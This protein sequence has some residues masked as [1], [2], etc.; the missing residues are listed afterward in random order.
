[1]GT[2]CCAVD[3]ATTAS[4]EEGVA[5]I[6]LASDGQRKAKSKSGASEDKDHRKHA[7]ELQSFIQKRIKL[8]EEYKQR[9]DQTVSPRFACPENAIMDQFRFATIDN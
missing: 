7:E 8:F 2:D 4:V 1:M 6:Q 5:N 9:E 3:S